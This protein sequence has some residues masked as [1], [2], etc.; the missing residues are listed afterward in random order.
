DNASSRRMRK[1]ELD[2]RCQRMAR[3]RT[4]N[5]IAYLEGLVEDFRNR[6]SSGQVATLM[7]QLSDM[8]KERD[9]LAKTLQSIQNSIQTHR[10][11]FEDVNQPGGD[12]SDSVAK[13]LSRSP[14]RVVNGIDTS[15]PD[16]NSDMEDTVSNAASPPM[17]LPRV[18]EIPSLKPEQSVS[19]HSSSIQPTTPP[20]LPLDPI[21]SIPDY[22][23]LDEDP[24]VPQ[25]SEDCDCKPKKSFLGSKPTINMWRYANQVLT[26]PAPL[27]R[28]I[29]ELEDSAAD[30]MPVRALIEGW[31]SVKKRYGGRLPPSWQKLRRIDEV[32]FG[33]CNIRERLAMMRIM[34]SLMRYHTDMTDERR[35]KVPAWYMQRP[36]QTIAHSY[37]IDYFAWPGLR[38]RFV[39][40]QHRYCG[41][42]F[43][44]LFCSSLRILWPFEFRDC[45]T[46]NLQTGQYHI[47]PQFDERIG[48][49]NAW[50]M[51]SDIYK[52]WP[53]FYSDIPA[54]N[55]IPSCV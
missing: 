23:Y 55:H 13:K 31:D 27:S 28:E 54:F 1:R 24:I 46:R 43:W 16:V 20:S 37:A 30:D 36:S 10:N 26:R 15:I 40:Y 19:G 49:I 25:T 18:I 8:S 2:R 33:T 5:R 14:E 11:L 12:G 29:N 17:V 44:K 32:I 50:T 38:E 22:G 6:D 42:L 39:F 9:L 34:H 3:E 35:A 41:N 45:Y 47:S 21:D 4:K 48:D 51:E 52:R 7:N 53:E